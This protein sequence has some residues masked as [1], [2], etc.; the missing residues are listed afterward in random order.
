[1]ELKVAPKKK[2]VAEYDACN[3]RRII[4]SNGTTILPVDGVYSSEDEEVAGMLAYYA[5]K[6]IIKLKEK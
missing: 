4:L 1:M 2:E 3:L 5:E 6:G